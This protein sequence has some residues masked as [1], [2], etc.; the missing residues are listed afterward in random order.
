MQLF[1]TNFG[2]MGFINLY[3]LVFQINHG[4]RSKAAMVTKT[5]A[6]LSVQLQAVVYLFLPRGSNNL[7]PFW[8][9]FYKKC[10]V[11]PWTL[12]F[13]PFLKAERGLSTVESLASWGS[14][15]G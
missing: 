1:I 4:P 9:P 11:S 10:L 12:V 15:W 14:L 2:L 13:I 3:F 5:D 7:I 8:K 6:S